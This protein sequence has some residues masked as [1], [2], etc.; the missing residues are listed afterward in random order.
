MLAFALALLV[1]VAPTSL[2]VR[3]LE[4]G[5]EIPE[6]RAVALLRVRV[7][8][9]ASSETSAELAQRLLATVRPE[10]FESFVSMYEKR[11]TREARGA[12][13]TFSRAMLDSVVA[14]AVFDGESST[15]GPLTGSDGGVYHV[16]RIERDAACR[17]VL[18]A[19]TDAAARQR[20]EALARELRAGADFAQVARERS[21]DPASALRGG[22]LAIYERGRRDVLLRAAAF[23][24]RVGEVVGP[25]ESPLGFHVLQ[26]VG[27]GA[28]PTSL[29]DDS[30]ARV[31]GILI[32]FAGAAGA[33]PDA[34]REHDAAEAFANEL[35]QR[36]ARGEDMAQLAALHDD[37][38]G[39]RER[40]G[41]LGWV[42]RATT[43]MPQFFDAL[44]T[45]PPG[46]LIGPIATRMGFVLLRREDPG[47]RTRIE[48]RRSAL[49][50]LDQWVAAASPDAA[51]ASPARSA[52][53]A[54]RELLVVEPVGAAELELAV[55]VRD[56]ASDLAAWS[57]LLPEARRESYLSYAQALELL[58]PEFLAQLWPERSQKIEGALARLRERQA[59]MLDAALDAGLRDLRAVDPR[60]VVRL[61]AVTEVTRSPD[62][63]VRRCVVA[64]DVASMFESVLANSLLSAAT[65]AGSSSPVVS[66]VRAAL[67]VRAPVCLDALV[68][69]ESAALVRRA[70]AVNHR[71]P[72]PTDPLAARVAEL[73][74]GH[75]ERGEPLEA[76]LAA[77][78]A[79]AP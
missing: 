65:D 13:G 19:G 75:V 12:L 10:S 68:R 43:E 47:L 11:P 16:R 52:A 79:L 76:T 35:A 30:W 49:A 41:D 5:A 23:G 4:L 1:Q 44:F 8:D 17:Q 70:L 59:T 78:E 18:V 15:A 34:G 63:S 45:E 60:V 6:T 55:A 26:R 22:D 36:I 7:E 71:S 25:V 57:R 20:A 74:L 58:E 48:V 9:P 69:A 38:R 73:W 27:P 28:L 14:G 72:P 50:E 33:R 51:A 62:G 64:G 3:P 31:R 42:R 53:R 21:E 29:R 2:L 56:T 46:S 37:D 39:G 32:A 24:A 66:R 54:L 40:R 67:G 61:A 77:I